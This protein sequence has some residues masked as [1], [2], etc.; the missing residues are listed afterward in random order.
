MIQQSI[1]KNKIIFNIILIYIFSRHLISH[2]I[3]I[4]YNFFDKDNILD[5]ILERIYFRDINENI[6]I[7]N[8]FLSM[9][10]FFFIT[11]FISGYSKWESKNNKIL[12]L[13][14]ISLLCIFIQIFVFLFN[15][16]LYSYRYESQEIA[17]S[18]IYQLVVVIFS[19]ITITL[20][21]ISESCIRNDDKSKLPILLGLLGTILL[22]STG[23]NSAFK[24]LVFLIFIFSFKFDFIMKFK[25]YLTSLFQYRFKKSLIIVLIFSFCLISLVPNIYK[26]GISR[27]LGL[28]IKDLS[29]EDISLQF[30]IPVFIARVNVDNYS[31]DANRLDEKI[32]EC[33][34]KENILINTAL[35]NEY[36]LGAFLSGR[37]EKFKNTNNEPMNPARVNIL[38]LNKCQEDFFTE[39]EGTGMTLPAQFFRLL[40][41]NSPINFVLIPFFYI[42]FLKWFWFVTGRYYSYIFANS[43]IGFFIVAITGPLL[44]YLSIENLL[45]FVDETII[46]TFL[47][48]YF[49][50]NVDNS[51]ITSHRI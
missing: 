43:K 26:I 12:L 45:L 5:S 7:F 50:D 34:A 28:D 30:A 8:I 41:E 47:F 22:G 48:I 31:L 23:L 51:F 44:G 13:K 25:F 38:A 3:L 36:R 16:E 14:I 10:I 2:F 6:L 4:F 39:K 40:K 19:Q 24:F 35:L 46:S 15:R 1:K 32:P 33:V 18:G 9:I 29:Q 11:R 37:T 27:K 20:L 49:R 42:Y 21:L 17:T